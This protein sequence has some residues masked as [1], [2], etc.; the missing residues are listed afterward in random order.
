[1]QEEKAIVKVLHDLRNLH[2]RDSRHN[3]RLKDKASR[4]RPG[5][6]LP[7]AVGLQTALSR[8]PNRQH[9]G[10]LLGLQAHLA[11]QPTKGLQARLYPLV[12]QHRIL[13]QAEVTAGP[14]RL[15][16]M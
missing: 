11:L 3:S 2:L 6:A 13:P 15:D 8:V 5:R 9:Q 4:C 10:P 14:E 16:P 1:M 7:A 12:P